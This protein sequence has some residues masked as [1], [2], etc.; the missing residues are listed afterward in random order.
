M[1]GSLLA[2]ADAHIG[3]EDRSSYLRRLV[4]ADLQAA[5]KLPGSPA[6]EARRKAEAVI[7]AFSDPKDASAAF[8]ELL[9]SAARKASRRRARK[10]A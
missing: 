5:G 2:A 4:T 3:N 6:E 7:L 1:P 9:V 8:D 10:A